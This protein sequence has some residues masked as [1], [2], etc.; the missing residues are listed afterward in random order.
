[1]KTTSNNPPV[2]KL[3]VVQPSTSRTA[4]NA[5]IRATIAADQA[6]SIRGIVDRDTPNDPFEDLFEPFELDEGPPAGVEPPPPVARREV[7]QQ[8]PATRQPLSTVSCPSCAASNPS[9]NRHCE[10]CGARIQSSPL[11]VAPPPAAKM[12]PG[13]RALGVL[14]G[15]LVVV[16]VISQ[17]IG[18]DDSADTTTTTATTSS[19][20]QPLTLSLIQP[21]AAVA[22]SELPGDFGADNLIDGDRTEEWQS[23]GDE[24]V[25][26]EIT[27]TWTEPVAISEI[28]IYNIVDETRFKRNFRIKDFSIT[29]NDIALET[30]GSLMNTNDEQ[31]ISIATLKT[32]ELKLKVL[33][34][35]PAEAVGTATPFNEIAIAEVEFYGR[36]ATP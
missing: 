27:F 30:S 4:R 20:T 17:L 36:V 22:S 21:G 3:A 26:A 34:T 24:G 23:A 12:T 14:L 15:V 25:G 32:T 33:S 9:T 28:R 13:G 6:L 2:T 5:C 11:P 31:R 1:M 18:G 10:S 19:T 35:Y 8:I 7:Q 16:F 29:V